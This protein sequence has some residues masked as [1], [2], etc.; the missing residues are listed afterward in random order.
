MTRFETIPASDILKPYVKNLVISENPDEK[1]Y[2]VYPSD[3]LVI[4][5]QYRGKL[6]NLHGQNVYPLASA[7]ITGIHDKVRLFKNSADTGTILVVFNATGASQFFREPVHEL[8]SLSL[9][10]DHFL[11][12][13]ELEEIEACLSEAE[14]DLQRIAIVENFLVSRLREKQKDLLVAQ[15]VKLIRDANGTIRI[16]ELN[17]LLNI[18]QSPLEKRF[19]AVVGTS[20][21]K[22]SSII[23]FNSVL[24]ALQNGKSLTQLGYDNQYFDQA[25]FIH[26]FRNFTGET[27]ERFLKELLK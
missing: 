8:F 27:P 6:A 13:S 1:T 20:P 12:H 3:G 14:T 7:G 5:F 21:K 11:P 2:R 26:D 4:G 25:H 15:A 19:R 23:R 16:H 17:K 18:S 9:P 22:F 10:L 24:A